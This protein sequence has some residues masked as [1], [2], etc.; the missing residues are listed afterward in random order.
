VKIG[1]ESITKP[2][3]MKPNQTK[4]HAGHKSFEPLPIAL[5]GELRVIRE[6]M[7]LSQDEIAKL[8]GVTN[9]TWWRWEQGRQISEH[10]T[11]KVR[12]IYEQHLER[13]AAVSAAATAGDGRASL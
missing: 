1:V 13:I 6:Q 12:E 11:S 8:V 2:K 9:Y 7:G 3:H 10:Y 4:P 5:P